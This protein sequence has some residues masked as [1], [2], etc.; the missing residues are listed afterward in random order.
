[1]PQIN[2]CGP[3][4]N[5]VQ[6]SFVLFSTLT[7]QINADFIHLLASQTSSRTAQE[8]RDHQAFFEQSPNKFESFHKNLLDF[9]LI[10]RYVIQRI[11]L[12]F[13][14]PGDKA[15]VVVYLSHLFLFN[16]TFSIIVF[17]LPHFLI[18]SHRQNCADY[19]CDTVK[20]AFHVVLSFCLLCRGFLPGSVDSLP[21]TENKCF[22][23]H[24]PNIS[25]S[26][27]II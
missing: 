16:F 20:K 5:F 10:R 23:V 8:N 3:V 24:N 13:L 4:L 9:W 19:H 12:D 17:V 26:E 7:T 1:M 11:A 15:Q 21:V 18:G 2:R 14:P 22:L 6:F 25:L 27:H